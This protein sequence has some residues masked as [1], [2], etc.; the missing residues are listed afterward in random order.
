M[1]ETAQFIK[2]GLMALVAVALVALAAK[3]HDPIMAFHAVVGALAAAVTI[4]YWARDYPRRAH[5]VGG[6]EV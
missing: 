1:T 2:I 3:A 5:T 6:Q 4:I